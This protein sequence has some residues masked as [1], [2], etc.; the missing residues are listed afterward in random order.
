MSELNKFI[1]F[2]KSYWN[3]SPRLRHQVARLLLSH[4]HQVVFFEKPDFLFGSFKNQPLSE[5]LDAIN[6]RRAR[7]LIHHQLRVSNLLRSLNAMYEKESIGKKI[8]IEE[9]EGSII[10]NF[11]YDYYFLRNLFPKNKIITIINDDF[12]AQSKINKGRH[13]VESLELTCKISDAV[14]VVSYPLASQVEKWCNPQIFLPWAQAGYIRPNNLYSRDSILI[15]AHVDR[16]FDFN[17]LKEFAIKRPAIKIDFFGPTSASV[18]QNILELRKQF[19]K[20]TFN[21]SVDLDGIVFD[22]YFCSII[23]YLKDVADINA[24]SVSNKTF[25]LLSKGMPIVTHGMPNFINDKAIFKTSSVDGFIGAIDFCYS[26]F[27][28][29]QS[30]IEDIVLKNQPD[31]RYK[32]IMSVVKN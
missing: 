17:L 9:E 20:F 14:F 4:G 13:V 19:E 5:D 30:S 15:W 23:P 3:E 28:S 7:Q 18:A 1:I 25:Q 27:F 11:N 6:I 16:R 12:V 8:D 2:S 32:Q 22:K 24:V 29:L 31:S 21:S 10:I 26:N